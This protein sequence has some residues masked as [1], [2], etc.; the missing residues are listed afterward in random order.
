MYLTPGH[1]PGTIST[2][3]HVKDHGTPHTVATWGGT[4]FNFAPKPESFLPYIRSA[5]RFRD[6][7]AKAGADVILSNHTAYDNTRSK[8]AALSTRKPKERHPYVIGSAQVQR[9]ITTAD[10]CAKAGYIAT[11]TLAASS[12]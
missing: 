5:E 2:I 6:I 8:V 3:F 10:E 1:T 12:N 4:A 7:V 9:Y 11:S